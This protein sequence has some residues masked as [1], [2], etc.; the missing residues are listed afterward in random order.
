MASPPREEWN[1]EQRLGALFLAALLGWEW[2]WP[3]SQVTDTRGIGWFAL[4]FFLFLTLDTFRVSA[5]ISIPAKIVVILFFLLAF[6]FSPWPQTGEWQAILLGETIPEYAEEPA[7]WTYFVGPPART[8]AFFLLLWAA[9][10]LLVHWMVRRRRV[11]FPLL[12]TIVYL[13]IL[14]SFTSFDGKGAVVR[15]IVYGFI[16]LTWFCLNRLHRDHPAAS[17]VNG[18]FAA[19]WTLI[20]L[21]IGIGWLAPKADASWPDPVSWI[22]SQDERAGSQTMGQFSG[23]SSDDRRLGGPFIQD[24]RVAFRAEVEHPYYWR[25][26]SL[27]IYTGHGWET[28]TSNP[29]AIPIHIYPDP[30]IRVPSPLLLFHNLEVEKNRATIVWNQPR[31]HVLF[32]PGQLRRADPGQPLIGESGSF[33]LPYDPPGRYSVTAEIPRIDEEKLRKSSMKYPEA[34]TQVYLQLPDTLPDR[35]KKK[36]LEITADA[37]NPYDKARAVEQF[38]KT[39]GFRYEIQDVPVPKESEDF[40]DQFLFDTKQGYCNHFSSAMVVLLRAADVPARWVKGF[41][42]GEAKWEDNRYQ[43]TVRNADAHSWVEVYFNDIGWVPFEPTPGFSN[44]TPIEREETEIDLEETGSQASLASPDNRR[45]PNERDPTAPTSSDKEKGRSFKKESR[46][47]WWSF[48]LLLLAGGVVWSFRSRLVW[49]WLH[50]YPRIEEG[51]RFTLIRAYRLF[52]RL[53]AWKRGPRKPHQTAREYIA[54]DHWLF[55]T[56]SSEMREITRLFEQARYG[57]AEKETFLWNR[58]RQLWRTLLKQT[59][60]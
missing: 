4:A 13:S 20:A 6:Y 26:E 39:G 55:S 9:A 14:D 43:V 29:L 59:R 57:K 44:P 17:A 58:A 33:F 38:L 24:Q 28:N 5:K 25:G 45:N 2:L 22:T 42:P 54:G 27:D 10:A 41:A 35:V 12:L 34:I 56:P 36:A 48:T 15:T 7:L 53:L 49:W 23:Y 40:V 11:M 18:W 47:I 30:D 46:W 1:L 31:Y 52:L 3:L 60:P 37:D 19:T 8:V 21:T 51:N 32:T 50:R 16:C